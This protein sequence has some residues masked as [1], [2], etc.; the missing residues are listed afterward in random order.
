MSKFLELITHTMY[1]IF[2]LENLIFILI[3]TKKVQGKSFKVMLWAKKKT[4]H[5]LN[6]VIYAFIITSLGILH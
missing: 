6:N 2:L 5:I 4:K 1:W 3:Y